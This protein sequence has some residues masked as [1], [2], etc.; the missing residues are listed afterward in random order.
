MHAGIQVTWD[1][2]VLAL[3]FAHVLGDFVF[4][5]RRMVEA[6]AAGARVAHLRHA[7]LHYLLA[8]G[9]LAL[10]VPAPLGS[11]SGQALLLGLA[12]AHLAIDFGKSR[13]GHGGGALAFALDQACHLATIALCALAMAGQPAAALAAG[14]GILRANSAPILTVGVVYVGLVFGCGH[15]IGSL[16]RPLREK[17]DTGSKDSTEQLERAGM[18]IGW[19]ERFLLLTAIVTGSFAAVG[20]IVAAKSLFRFP[21]LKDRPFAEYFLIGTLLSVVA[22]TLGGL[23]LVALL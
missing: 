23:L 18:Y 5:S 10:F 21:E 2:I 1:S 4:Q 8:L 9:L 17:L 13:L 16:L 7:M 15:L 14:V 19:L 12:I 20:L 22:A 3:L 6:K 11:L